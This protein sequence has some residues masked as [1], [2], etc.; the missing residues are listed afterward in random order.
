MYNIV[1]DFLTARDIVDANDTQHAGDG[2]RRRVLGR[3]DNR[4]GPA[5]QRCLSNADVRRPTF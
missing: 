5:G 1:A 4:L 2:G 3:T